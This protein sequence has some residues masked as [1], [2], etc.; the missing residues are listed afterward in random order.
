MHIHSSVSL[1]HRELVSPSSTFQKDIYN[2]SGLSQDSKTAPGA[3]EYGTFMHSPNQALPYSLP[4]YSD[5]CYRLTYLHLMLSFTCVYV[6]VNSVSQE[7]P[8]I[9]NNLRTSIL[10]CT[11]DDCRVEA[12][13]KHFSKGLLV[14]RWLGCFFLLHKVF[15]THCLSLF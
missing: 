7:R 14:I 10:I 15:Q 3:R 5:I 2:K 6:Y 8:G 9:L 12:Q 4:N 13:S 1:L 11:S